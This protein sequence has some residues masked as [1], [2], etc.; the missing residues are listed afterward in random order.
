MP[1]NYEVEEVVIPAV[2]VPVYKRK[3]EIEWVDADEKNNG[4]KFVVEREG[5]RI[6]FKADGEKLDV[7][8]AEFGNQTLR[9]LFDSLGDTCLGM[10][11]DDFDVI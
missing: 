2:V 7:P 8:L 9:Q 3:L 11:P 10:N 5:K 4:V 6:T 1:R